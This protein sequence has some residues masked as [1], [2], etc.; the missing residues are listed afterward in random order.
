MKVSV[1][2]ED[3]KMRKRRRKDEI[4]LYINGFRR[5]RLG[6]PKKKV[7]PVNLENNTSNQIPFFFKYLA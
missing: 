4:N 6:N 3:E 1:I 2:L 5:R 7:S